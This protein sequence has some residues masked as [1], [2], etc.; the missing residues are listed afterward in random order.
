MVN[1]NL[2]TLTPIWTGDVNRECKEIKE[3]GI[4]GSMRWWY[5]ALVRGMGGYACDPSNI[6]CKF[7]TKGYEDNKSSEEALEIGLK[8][9]CPACRLFGCTGWKRRFRVE[10]GNIDIVDLYFKNKFEYIN[11]EQWFKKTHK[12]NPKAFYSQDVLEMK[13]IS[14]NKE[15]ETKIFILLR[16]IEKLGTFGAKGQNGFGIVEL[17][18]DS[19]PIKFKLNEEIKIYKENNPKKSN[20]NEYRS[21]KNIYK[22]VVSVKK[23]DTFLQHFQPK[24]KIGNYI[25]TSF[26]IKYYLRKKIKEFDDEKT[27]K[28][29][30]NYDEVL[31]QIKNKYPE[32]KYNHISKIV[33]RT[34]FGSDLKDE[35]D[36]GNKKLK[37]DDLRDEKKWSSL[38]DISHIFKK[39]NEYQFRIV[40]SLPKI[41]TY[42]GINIE[43]D[44]SL[45]IDEIIK[46]IK[47]VFADSYLFSWEE[48]P[49]NDS[50]KLTNYLKSIYDVDWVKTAKISKIDNDKTVIITDGKNRL[51]LTLN[52]ENTE[53]NLKIGNDKTDEFFVKT[54]NGKKNIYANSIKIDQTWRGDEILDNLLDGK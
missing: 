19:P 49:G 40:C 18:S 34:L 51:S 17:I 42:D 3:T 2:K 23:I 30:L 22:F 39:D 6:S 36:L 35:K 31:S 8:E 47:T 33:A 4:I 10:L 1:F 38:I 26:V 29:L 44:T 27:S 11:T 16:L 9:V 12:T 46:L 54:E 7:D 14:D 45:V 20:F 41:V 32:K 52:N 37:R 28:L 48:I 15:I 43:F 50:I 24:N 13:L 25:L 5:E 21:L 53:L